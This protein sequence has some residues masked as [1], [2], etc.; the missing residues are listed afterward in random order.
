LPAQ[1]RQLVQHLRRLAPRGQTAT[2]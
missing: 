1:A 2:S